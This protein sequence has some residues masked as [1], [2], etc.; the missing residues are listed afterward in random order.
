MAG[1]RETDR[2]FLPFGYN[3]YVAFWEGHYAA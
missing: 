1:F 2:V 3:V